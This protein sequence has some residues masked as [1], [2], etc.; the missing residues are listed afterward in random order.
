MNQKIGQAYE[1]K[2][3]QMDDKDLAALKKE[4]ILEGTDL[5][6]QDQYEAFLKGE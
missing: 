2:I 5:D 1:D 4:K 6:T 3:K